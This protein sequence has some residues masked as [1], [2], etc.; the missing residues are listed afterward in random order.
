MTRIELAVAMPIHGLHLT[1][2]FDGRGLRQIGLDVGDDLADVIGHAAEIAAVGSAEDIDGG[3]RVVVRERR[4]ARVAL[5]RGKRTENI[6][7]PVR[8]QWNVR[9]RLQ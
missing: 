8:G 5:H 6:A 7:A 9:E 1:A 4:V 2:H 3:L